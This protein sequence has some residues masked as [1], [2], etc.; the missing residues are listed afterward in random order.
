MKQGVHLKLFANDVKVYT[1]IVQCQLT[2]VCI[3]FF[4][5]NMASNWPSLSANVIHCIS[6]AT[7]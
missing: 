1:E 4:S 3:R 2:V 6:A 5:R 7:I